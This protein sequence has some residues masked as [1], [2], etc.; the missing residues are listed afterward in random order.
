M[1]LFVLEV[2]NIDDN[3]RLSWIFYVAMVLMIVG[4]VLS[5]F[6]VPGFLRL[7]MKF[8]MLRWWLV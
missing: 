8:P 4:L 6:L 3:L 2:V 7:L 5:A 1:A